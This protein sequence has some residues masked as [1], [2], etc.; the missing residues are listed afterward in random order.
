MLFCEFT[1]TQAYCSVDPLDQKSLLNIWSRMEYIFD[2]HCR[3]M[4]IHETSA[5]V[6][7]K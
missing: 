2:Y 7:R 6:N 1:A 5:Q 3:T 4:G